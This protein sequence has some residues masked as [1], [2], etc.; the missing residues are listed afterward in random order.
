MASFFYW[1]E[2]VLF[3]LVLFIGF[4]SISFG[5]PGT[6]IILL[7]AILYGGLTHFQILTF[8]VLVV[9]GLLAVCGEVLEFFLS[10]KGVKKAKPSKGVVL[11]SFLSGLFL[12]IMMAPLFLGIGAIV[13]AL[14][15]TFGGAFLMEYLTQRRMSHAVHV[16]WK[17]FL[18]RLAGFLSKMGVAIL[19]FVIIFSRLFFR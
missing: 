19:M 10:I 16:G 8:N 14:V 9:L 7:A 2:T 5:I 13:G 15:G 6:W 18:G 3:I 1:A 12:A 4:L 11:V 17:A